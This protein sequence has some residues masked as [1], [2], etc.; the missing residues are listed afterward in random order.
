MNLLFEKLKHE[1]IEYALTMVNNIIGSFADCS[2]L[3]HEVH[4]LTI[5]PC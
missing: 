5:I 2:F 3:F 1:N 4:V